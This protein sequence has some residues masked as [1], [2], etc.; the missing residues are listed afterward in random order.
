MSASV[1]L[2]SSPGRPA[3]GTVVARLLAVFR[4]EPRK[5]FYPREIERLRL[6]R[7][8]QRADADLQ[9]RFKAM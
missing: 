1:K 9:A 8:M 7:E 6:E 4:E 3:L 5:P 2:A